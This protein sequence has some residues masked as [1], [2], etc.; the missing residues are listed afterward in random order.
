MAQTY[1]AELEA[2]VGEKGDGVVKVCW[3]EYP[4]L[5]D[6]GVEFLVGHYGYNEHHDN[7]NE[8]DQRAI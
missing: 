6:G 3:I 4:P 8:Q 1:K 7:V 2:M 5:W